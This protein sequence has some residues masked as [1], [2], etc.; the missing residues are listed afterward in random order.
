MQAEIL[1]SNDHL[2]IMNV[3]MVKTI[4][5]NRYDNSPRFTFHT[6]LITNSI[7]MM[8]FKMKS[9]WTSYLD[10]ATLSDSVSKEMSS[11]LQLQQI[12]K[13]GM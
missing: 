12:K 3:V 11:C 6:V 10:S 4:N 13:S 9:L 8:L 7:Y 1:S 2:I 5:N